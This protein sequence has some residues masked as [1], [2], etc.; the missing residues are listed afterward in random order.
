[1]ARKTRVEPIFGLSTPLLFAH[2]GGVR[3][4]PESTTKGFNHALQEAHAGVLELDVQLTKDGEFVVW[5]GPELSNVRIEGQSD[6][7]SERPLDRRKI[8]HYDWG[9]LHN[10]AWV[11]DPEIKDLPEDEI[12]LS[13]T[14]NTEDRQLLLLSVF[15]QKFPDSPLGDC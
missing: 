12:D 7:P 8:Y 13:K 9:E 10:K 5:H 4:A 1:M 2:R 15:M 14:E 6:R 3:E 11:A